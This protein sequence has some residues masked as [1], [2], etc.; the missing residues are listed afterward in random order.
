MP[1][2]QPRTCAVASGQHVHPDANALRS[3]PL[4]LANTR[5]ARA[6]RVHKR[7]ECPSSGPRIPT[8]RGS[9]GEIA[10]EACGHRES[11]GWAES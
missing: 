11:G 4:C 3:L 10:R 5:A 8:A 7:F 1:W 2:G 9:A 6:V